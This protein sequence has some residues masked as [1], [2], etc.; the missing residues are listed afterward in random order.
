MLYIFYYVCKDLNMKEHWNFSELTAPKRPPRYVRQKKKPEVPSGMNELAKIVTDMARDIKIIRRTQDIDSAD[1]WAKEFN[2]KHNTNYEALVTDLN[3]DKIPEVVVRDK[4]N[5]NQLITVNGYTTIPSS[6]PDTFMYGDTYPYD[7]RRKMR[8]EGSPYPNKAEWIRGTFNNV[9]S[10]LNKPFELDISKI[11]KNRYD[12]LGG[13]DHVISKGYKIKDYSQKE[14]YSQSAYQAFNKYVFTPIFR[15]IKESLSKAAKDAGHNE[16]ERNWSFVFPTIGS[17]TKACADSYQ[18]LIIIPVIKEI[19]GD[20]FDKVME[21]E[22]AIKRLKGKSSFKIL[23]KNTVQRYINNIANEANE[24]NVDKADYIREVIEYIYN[25]NEMLKKVGLLNTKSDLY[26]EAIKNVIKY[27][28]TEHQH[29]IMEAVYQQQTGSP[30]RNPRNINDIQYRNPY[31]A[32][33]EEEDDEKNPNAA[34]SEED[35]T[36]VENRVPT[37]KLDPHL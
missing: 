26:E 16:F 23:L 37:S 35:D 19:V 15:G 13:V 14:R 1:V 25:T 4:D 11:N 34:M 27:V 3:N 29:F 9:K 10:T 22:Y 18:S 28:M 20:D 21:N 12:E 7:L 8:K 17:I 24:N 33:D 2:A 31:V 5:P 32:M 36:S 30:K 6:W